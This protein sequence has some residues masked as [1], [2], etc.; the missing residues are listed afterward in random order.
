MSEFF[1][2]ISL[3]DW[4]NNS[5]E[6]TKKLKITSERLKRFRNACLVALIIGSTIY[7]VSVG[8]LLFGVIESALTALV[9]AAVGYISNA[10][11]MFC[12]WLYTKTS[13]DE[14]K[15]IARENQNNLF[16]FTSTFLPLLGSFVLFKEYY[17]KEKKEYRFIE[18]INSFTSFFNLSDVFTGTS[19][20][21]NLVK[22]EI[23]EIGNCI[24]KWFYSITNSVPDV[25]KS[26]PKIVQGPNLI[27]VPTCKKP[28]TF[29]SK[30]MFGAKNMIKMLVF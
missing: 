20:I 24:H 18:N 5:E 12:G 14:I 15:L 25:R 4:I 7:I 8:G 9:G 22:I 17:E 11:A 6:F 10:I 13:I 3:D 26:V 19:N 28:Q 2:K 23:N 21:E 1:L 16:E 29:L 30:I 27:F